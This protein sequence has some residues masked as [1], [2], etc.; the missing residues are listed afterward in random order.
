MKVSISQIYIEPGVS[1]PFSH[2]FQRLF[3]GEI[4]ALVVPS[5]KF[6]EKYGSDFALIFRMSAKQDIQ[7]NEIRG[8][9]VFRKAKDVEYT[10]FLPFDVICRHPEVPKTA[11]RFLLKGVCSVFESLRI[12]TARVLEKQEA[13]IEQVCSDPMMFEEEE[14]G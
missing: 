6:I 8:P 11:L 12:D 1:F 13:L 9:T 5:V 7:G 10:I 14:D 4:T 2:H 3:S